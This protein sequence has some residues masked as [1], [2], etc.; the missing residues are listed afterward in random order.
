MVL[1]FEM[2]IFEANLSLSAFHANAG[3]VNVET[4]Q[5]KLS[6]TDNCIPD[7]ARFF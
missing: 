5:S 7:N 2:N 4:K 3:S 1:Y 6:P